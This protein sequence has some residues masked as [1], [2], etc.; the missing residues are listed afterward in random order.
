MN[1]PA[2]TVTKA[3]FARTLGVSRSRV[4]ALVKRGLPVRSDGKIDLPTALKWVCENVEQT[5]HF[6][7]RGVNKL[8]AEVVVRR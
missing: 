5:T 8:N 7:D 4:T 3:A 1:L 6:P 2:E